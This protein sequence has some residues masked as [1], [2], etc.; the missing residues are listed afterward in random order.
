MGMSVETLLLIAVL[1]VL[2]LIQQLM[3]AQRQRNR[4]RTAQAESRSDTIVRTPP[5]ELA[6][7]VPDTPHAESDAPAAS[8][9]EPVSSHTSGPLTLTPRLEPPKGQSTAMDLGT[10]RDLRRAIVLMA[11]L[12]PC[13]ATAPYDVPQQ[14]SRSRAE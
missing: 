9:S 1:I 6:P 4:P 10:R 8:V 3:Q 14:A 5:S 12:G 2:P 13:R 11:T 7:P